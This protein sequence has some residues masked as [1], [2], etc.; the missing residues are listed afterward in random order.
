MTYYCNASRSIN[1]PGVDFANQSYETQKINMLERKCSK[2][3]FLSI[4]TITFDLFFSCIIQIELNC[5]INDFMTIKQ[6]IRRSYKW[7]SVKGICSL[8]VL[9]F[10]LIEL[11]KMFPSRLKQR[12]LERN[13]NLQI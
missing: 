7:S 2:N 10:R 9:W 5:L 1:F 6:F 4:T 12:S 13:F 8:L 3:I 11:F